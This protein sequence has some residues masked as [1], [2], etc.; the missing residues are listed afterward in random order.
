MDSSTISIDAGSSDPKTAIINQVKQEAAMTNARQLI[1]VCDPP[2][3][4]VLSHCSLSNASSR[5]CTG[6][7]LT[8]MFQKLNDHCFEKC[9]PTPGSSLSKKEE[10]CFTM[11]MEK[12][13]AAWNA[14]SRAY[15]NRIPRGGG[16]APGVGELS[17]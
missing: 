2:L 8:S 1:S 6:L 15:V 4:C 17:M 16:Q 10:Q 7:L 9:I 13:L 11:C 12:Y 3:R 14:V 5:G